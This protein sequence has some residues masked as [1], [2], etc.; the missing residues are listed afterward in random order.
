MFTNGVPGDGVYGFQGEI[1]TSTPEQTDTYSALTSQ[2]NVTWNE[3]AIPI[4]LDSEKEMM[5][6]EKRGLI[7]LT[8]EDVVL[9]MPQ[10]VWPEGQMPVKANKTLTNETP[11]VGAQVLDIDLANKT[12]TFIA[13]KGWDYEGRTI[14]FIVTDATPIGPAVSLGVPY[15][16]KNAA[17]ISNPAA[18]DMFHFMNGINGSGPFGFQPGISS[19]S[20]VDET[21]SPMSRIYIVTWNDP[22]SATLLLTK[23]VIDQFEKDELINVEIAKPMAE[24]H[25]VNTP[26]VDPYQNE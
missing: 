14:Y 4:I 25:I 1:F 10:T 3:G 24:D 15:T 6:A 8:K 26:I 21:Y 18:V 17:L 22:D 13:H 11:F 7:I 9:N 23:M 2:V 19:G 5:I 16:P 20:L 12:T